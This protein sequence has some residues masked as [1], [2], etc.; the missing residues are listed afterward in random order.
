VTVDHYRLSRETNRDL[1]E[2]EDYL[3]DHAPG[4]IDGVIDGMLSSV[5]SRA[6][7]AAR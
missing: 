1:F 7:E 2:I 4:A 6:S 3:E 5:P